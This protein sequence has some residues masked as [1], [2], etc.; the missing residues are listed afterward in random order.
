MTKNIISTAIISL[1]LL[2]LTG[3]ILLVTSLNTESQAD[4]VYKV[5]QVKSIKDDNHQENNL[6]IE[7]PSFKTPVSIELPV[8]Y[9][10]D[11]INYIEEVKTQPV[12]LSEDTP[13]DI[14]EVQ[15]QP[16]E[17]DVEEPEVIDES[18]DNITGHGGGFITEEDCFNMGGSLAQYYDGQ[19]FPTDG[20]ST[21]SVKNPSPNCTENDILNG[22]CA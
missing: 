11:S 20:N 9:T 3:S 7:K 21:R 12:T 14:K 5:K 16:I 22:Y 10:Q 17:V 2:A 6:Q 19:C 4:K 8:L 15:T 18:I 1:S 13:A